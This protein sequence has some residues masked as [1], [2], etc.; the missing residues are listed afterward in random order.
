[1]IHKP[2]TLEERID[3]AYKDMM[4]RYRQ[5]YVEAYREALAHLQSLLDQLPEEGSK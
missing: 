4:H 3:A 2:S 5:G 1:M